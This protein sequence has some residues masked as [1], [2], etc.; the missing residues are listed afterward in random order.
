MMKRMSYG[1]FLASLI[2]A[3]A[4]A[5]DL[6]ARAPGLWQST[7]TVTGPDG[8]PLADDTDVVTVSCVDA[9]DDQK[10][11][12]SDQN[13]CTGLT[14][15]GSGSNYSIDGTCSSPGQSVRIHETLVYAD[16]RNVM[17]TA[18]YNA[19]TGQMTVTSRLQW[20]GQCLPGMLPGDEGSMTGGMFS[21][22]DNINDTAN[23]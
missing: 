15:S 1:L 7:T 4:L 16:A 2:C 11:F 9:L 8:K 17:L 13:A 5:A 6:P 19:A 10:F 21:K 23:Q 3:P 14:I 22:V 12:T 18:I 20:Q